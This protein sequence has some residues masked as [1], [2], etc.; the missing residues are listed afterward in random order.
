[1]LRLSKIRFLLVLPALLAGVLMPA[2]LIAQDDPNDMPLGDVARSLRKKT[3][4]AQNVIDDD[5]FSKVMEQAENEHAASSALKLLMAGGEKGFQVS[6][7]D[8]T[9]SLSFSANAKSL[10]SS[11]YAQMELPAS[12]VLKLVGP[13][14]I[15]GDALIVS[16]DN[17]TD[18]HVS[19]IAVALTVLK[20]RRAVSMANDATLNTGV[21]F[22]PALDSN[23]SLESDVR[24]EK[25]PDM[26]VIYHLRAAGSPWVTTVFSTPLNLELAPDEEWHWAIVQ[27][28]GYPPQSY[29]GSAQQTTA[30]ANRPASMST[31]SFETSEIPVLPQNRSVSLPE[32]PAVESVSAPTK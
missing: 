8:A 10:L 18:W 15:E 5:N 31:V 23:S 7:P 9:C 2:S 29:R 1:M 13:A 25:K 17:R 11:G 21:T 32:N 3:P 19:E 12:E 16:V 22:M 6:A 24:P 26:T 14:T 28:R 30:E 27:A 20:K 4:P